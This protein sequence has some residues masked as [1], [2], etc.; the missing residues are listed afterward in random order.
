[1]YCKHP[2]AAYFPKKVYFLL[3]SDVLRAIKSARVCVPCLSNIK[4][5]FIFRVHLHQGKANAKAVSL[6]DG[7]GW[8]G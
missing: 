3:R 8:G 7:K 4:I 6:S 1:M 2:K 5:H